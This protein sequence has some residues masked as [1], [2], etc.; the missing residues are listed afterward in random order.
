MV[1]P[2]LVVALGVTALQSLSARKGSLTAV[3][4]QELHTREGLRLRVTIH[5]SALLRLP[6]EADKEAEFAQFV[7]DLKEAKRAAST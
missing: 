3:R 5:P 7:R 2:K 6:D 4:G 1:K